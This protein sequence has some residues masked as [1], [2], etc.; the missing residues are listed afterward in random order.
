MVTRVC[1]TG[2][3]GQLGRGFIR[4]DTPGWQFVGPDQPRI[5]VRDW[6]SV[7]DWIASTRPSYVIHAAAMT[8]VDGCER[9][10]GDAFSINAVGARHVA[11]AAERAGATLVYVSTNF[12][13]DGLKSAPYH[14]FD[15]TNPLSVYGESKL[16]GEREAIHCCR[17]CYVIR[18]AMVFDESGR[19]FVNTMLRLMS[20][21]SAVNVVDDQVGNP[22][23]APDLAAGIS[24]LVRKMPPGTYHLTN[25]GSTSWFG[26]AN[27][28]RRLR[29]VDCTVQPTDGASFERA[30]AVPGNGAM[31]SLAWPEAA[32]IMPEWRDALARCLQ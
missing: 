14:E 6:V 28:I 7:R 2:A 3:T 12:V 25:K 17:S 27:E 19:N 26:W 29:N 9:R 32:E 22:T 24:R 1:L 8:D 23:Y 5:D 11:A 10:P 18:T 13:F 4:A 31:E 21:R 30:A 20:E 16:A 15:R